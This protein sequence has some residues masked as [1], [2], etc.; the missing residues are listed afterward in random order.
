MK[1]LKDFNVKD[2]RVLVRCDFN[3][4]ISDNGEIIDDFRIR[5]TLPTIQHLILAKAKVVLMSHLQNPD[6]KVVPNLRLNNIAK[7]ISE[8]LKIKVAKADDCIG[9]EVKNYSYTLGEDEILLLEN[10]RF[11]KE[12]KENNIE[13]AKKISELGDIYIN[14]AFSVCHR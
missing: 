2:K 13:F 5:Q 3:V 6:G 12:E 11:H 14:D 7:K 1:V 10:L 9:D 4:P 8:Y